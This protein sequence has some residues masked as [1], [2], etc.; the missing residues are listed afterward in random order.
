VAK[1]QHDQLY[2]SNVINILAGDEPIHI[3]W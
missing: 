2:L 1:L 3:K